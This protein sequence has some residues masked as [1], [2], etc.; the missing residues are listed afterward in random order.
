[1][2]MREDTWGRKGRK[3]SGIT[4]FQLNKQIFGKHFLRTEHVIG[5]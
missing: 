4:E 5:I 2:Y 3:K 1:M